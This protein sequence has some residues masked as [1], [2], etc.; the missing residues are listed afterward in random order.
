MSS[1]ESCYP[2]QAFYHHY[3]S[4]TL[5]G[6]REN[7]EYTLQYYVASLVG[8]HSSMFQPVL[9]MFLKSCYP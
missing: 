9:V 5:P 3:T 1:I 2:E 6:V 4:Q 7:V 8:L